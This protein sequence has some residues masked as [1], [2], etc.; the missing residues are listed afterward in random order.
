M[1][2]MKN[3]FTMTDE[4]I[5][6]RIR[7]LADI[8]DYGC[9]DA[10]DVAYDEYMTL[11]DIENE[12]FRKKHQAAFDEFYTKYISGK[13]WEEIDP[14]DWST[15]SDWHKDMYGFRPRHI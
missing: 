12:R 11:R 14:D 10:W 8:L 2:T 6:K 4:E 15:Y 13:S 5:S 3:Y 9:S 7:E 1:D